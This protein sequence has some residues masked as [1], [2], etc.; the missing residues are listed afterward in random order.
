MSKKRGIWKRK[1]SVSLEGPVRKIRKRYRIKKKIEYKIMGVVEIKQA[2]SN[3]VD[4]IPEIA[5]LISEFTFDPIEIE[6][7]GQISKYNKLIG[8][9][10]T[11]Y[12]GCYRFLKENEHTLKG[13]YPQIEYRKYGIFK[14]I[15]TNLPDILEKYHLDFDLN[16]KHQIKKIIENEQKINEWDEPELDEV[17]KVW[18]YIRNYYEDKC[19]NTEHYNASPLRS[20]WLPFGGILWNKAQREAREM[21]FTELEDIWS[22]LV[23]KG[24]NTI[25][26]CCG[27]YTFISRCKFHGH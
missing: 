9:H 18:K 10:S 6:F 13:L 11:D 24:W 7:G 8:L 5:N 20:I 15:W 22:F 25:I 27:F 14:D 4:I 26:Q 12:N 21:G 16:L 3:S 17:D 2:I 1:A 23:F 19:R